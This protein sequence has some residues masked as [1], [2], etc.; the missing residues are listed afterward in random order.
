MFLPCDS[1]LRPYS[2]NSKY[3]QTLMHEDIH[4]NILNSN[5]DLKL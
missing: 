5:K 1:I 3:G 4:S 2:N